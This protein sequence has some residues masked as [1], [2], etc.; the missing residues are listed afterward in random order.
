MAQMEYSMQRLS[1]NVEVIRYDMSMMNRNIHDI[2]R[3]M[4][5]IDKFVPW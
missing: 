3:P 1:G 5:M 4:N 2:S